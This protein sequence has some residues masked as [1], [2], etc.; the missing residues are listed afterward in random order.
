[1]ASP[2]C[3]RIFE[4]TEIQMPGKAA[5]L[6][7]GESVSGNAIYQELEILQAWSHDVSLRLKPI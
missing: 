1:M 3:L 7:S 6:P 4:F 2:E 5:Q